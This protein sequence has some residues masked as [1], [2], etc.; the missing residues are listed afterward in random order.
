MHGT[1]I[2]SENIFLNEAIAHFMSAPLRILCPIKA[3]G[4]SLVHANSLLLV[5]L[6]QEL[7][8]CC[9]SSETCLL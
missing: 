7:F 3:E 1:K 8:H 4:L 2:Y 9:Y 6:L 5:F